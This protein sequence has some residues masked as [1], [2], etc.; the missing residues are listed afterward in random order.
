MQLIGIFGID[1][2]DHKRF[3]RPFPCLEPLLNVLNESGSCRIRLPHDIHPLDAS[4]IGFFERA[5]HLHAGETEG[6]KVM[7]PERPA[8]G[9]ALHDDEVASLPGFFQTFQPISNNLACPLPPVQSL[10][11]AHSLSL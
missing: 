11:S 4:K 2:G 7:E 9:L 10:S 8:V 6:R 3:P 5:Y 1:Q